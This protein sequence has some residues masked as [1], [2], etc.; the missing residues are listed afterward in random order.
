MAQDGRGAAVDRED[1]GRASRFPRTGEREERAGA[2]AGRPTRAP[3]LPARA[4]I[5]LD[6]GKPEPLIVTKL[7][8]FWHILL[9]GDQVPGQ[10][11][12]LRSPLV[13]TLTMTF[14]VLVS[15]SVIIWK[16]LANAPRER[17]YNASRETR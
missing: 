1:D 7:K 4:P 11:E 17:A 6:A 16:Q 5:D 14:V 10:E 15:I 2:G 13:I 8:R 3:E 9:V 12:I